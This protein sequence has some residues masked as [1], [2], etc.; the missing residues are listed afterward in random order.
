MQMRSLSAGSDIDDRCTKCGMELAHVIIAMD[1]P[2]PIKTQRKTCGSEHK[3][4]GTLGKPVAK[5]RST[6]SSST[7]RTTKV[8]TITSY[9]QAMLGRDIARARRYS[10]RETFESGEIVDHKTFGLGAVLK[11]LSGGKI[12]VCFQAG[13]KV[14]VHGR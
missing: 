12:E 14:L 9:E 3:Y 7:R 1:G 13:T 6:S 5:K 4:R 11:E 10:A 8:P 2:R